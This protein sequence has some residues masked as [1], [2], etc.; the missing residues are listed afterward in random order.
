M[1]SSHSDVYCITS[2]LYVA[3]ALKGSVSMRCRHFD[4]PASEIKFSFRLLSSDDRMDKS[5]D[6][7]VLVRQV[8][9]RSH[10]FASLEN[11]VAPPGL[12]LSLR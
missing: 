7:C 5:S 3:T 2:L 6:L 1:R 11:G 12:P 4:R 9:A 8:T 10:A